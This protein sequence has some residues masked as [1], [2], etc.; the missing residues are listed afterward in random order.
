MKEKQPVW[1]RK[2]QFQLFCKRKEIASIYFYYKSLENQ[3]CYLCYLNKGWAAGTHGKCI[4]PLKELLNWIL[5]TVHFKPVPGL[6]G[7]KKHLIRLQSLLSDLHSHHSLSLIISIKKVL[8]SNNRQFTTIFSRHL[9]PIQY[10]I[11]GHTQEYHL[12]E[13]LS[14]TIWGTHFL[15]S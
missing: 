13:W 10:F 12:I 14:G 4:G 8:N 7:S 1:K 2:T 5:F 3:S 6:T 9:F 15:S 11:F